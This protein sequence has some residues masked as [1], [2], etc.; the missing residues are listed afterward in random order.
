MINIMKRFEKF[1]TVILLSFITFSCFEVE[2]GTG[3]FLEPQFRVT[4]NAETKATKTDASGQFIVNGFSFNTFLVATKDVE[5]RYFPKP[6]EN[7]PT[8][9]AN[10]QLKSNK[11]TPLQKSAA[12][13]R[14]LR[15]I[16]QGKVK[17]AT[18]GRGNT[19]EG[20]YTEAE[21]SIYNRNEAGATDALKE[22]SLFIIG[23][24]NDVFTT[25]GM[26]SDKV[27]VAMTENPA[28]ILIEGES[29]MSLVF[30]L[31]L[32][33]A[34]VDFSKAVD[35]NGNGRIEINPKSKGAN[36]AI[37][38]KIQNNLEAAVKLK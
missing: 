15:L 30:D 19:V 16:E 8:E 4:L 33:F 11:N 9:P 26:K 24:Y 21:F 31:D 18:V 10:I 2:N 20:Q 13:G 14:P 28:G 34:E 38:N 25:I 3:Y 32:L 27:I 37:F 7:M 29:E 35:E 23:V 6:D 17:V 12:Q 36:A 1:L 22:R 5:M